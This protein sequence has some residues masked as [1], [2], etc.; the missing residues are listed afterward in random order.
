MIAIETIK[1]HQYTEMVY[2]HSSYTRELEIGSCRVSVCY[3]RHRQTKRLSKIKSQNFIGAYF[4][5][6]TS[7]GAKEENRVVMLALGMRNAQ[8]RA[9]QIR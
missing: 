3:S 9:N 7:T 4:P 6:P 1:F 5:I 2:M 8:D